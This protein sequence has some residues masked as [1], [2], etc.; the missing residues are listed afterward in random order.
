MS[1]L[2]YIESRKN[3]NLEE[4]KEFLNKTLVS[5]RLLLVRFMDFTCD[6]GNAYQYRVRL[7]RFSGSRQYWHGRLR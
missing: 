3:A 7:L 1:V 2:E 5:G 4:L 6:R